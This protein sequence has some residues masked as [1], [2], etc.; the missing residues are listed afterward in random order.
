MYTG[1]VTTW[2]GV[3]MDVREAKALEI[4]ARCRLIFD[5]GVWL[6]PAQSGGAVYRVSLAPD[7]STCTCEDFALR[8]RP[9]K[10]ILAARLVQA[11]EYGGQPPAIDTDVL[12]KTKSYQQDWSAYDEAQATEKHRFQVLLHDLCRGILE[13]PVPKR[14][15]RPHALRDAVFAAAFK[16]YSTFSSRRFSC[17]LQDAH[18]RGYLARPVPGRMVSFFLENPVLTP[19]LRDLITQSSLPLR[20]VE[21]TFAPDS[22]GFSTSRFVRWF[23]EKYGVERSGHEWVKAHALCGVKTNIVVA[24]EI[25][26]KNAA[27]CPQFA[28]LVNAAAQHF[29]VEQVA[30]DK[31]YLSKDNLELVAGLGG[32]AYIPFKVNS[33]EGTTGGIW[34]KMF[35]YFQFRREDFLKHYHQRSNAEST[36]S[37]VK[38]KF[39]DHVRS[40]TDTAMKNEVY[41]K[42]LCHN[43]CCVIME[44]CVVGIEAEFWP[45]GKGESPAVLPMQ[46]PG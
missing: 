22:S 43:I 36:F 1:A 45:G 8:A 5:Q 40:K 26:D 17:D 28:P 3:P 2:E 41:C 19:I 14:G 30:A 13:P 46:R 34:E 18:T 15:R 6:V 37:M 24:V 11:R 29:T 27:D 4:A 35:G 16:V 33:T 38:A 32:T 21:T 7:H 44:Q 9:C 10:H 23:D 20:A 31:A 25:L 39:R 42:F 12:P